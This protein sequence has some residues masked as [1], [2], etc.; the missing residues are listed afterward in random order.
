GGKDLA[1]VVIDDRSGEVVERWTGAQVDTK[2]ARGYQAAVAGQVNRWCIWWPLCVLC[3]APFVDPRRPLRLVHL[4]LLALL[5]FSVSLAF[6]N[7]AKIEA[8]VA[9]VYPVLAYLFLRMLVAGFRPAESR[10]RLLP[11]APR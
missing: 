3:L 4:D 9:L 8:S 6:F 5:G 1:E 7:H 11:F 10:D 2:L